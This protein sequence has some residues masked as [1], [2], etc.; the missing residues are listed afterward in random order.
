[1]KAAQYIGLGFSIMH[2]AADE[3]RM[4]TGQSLSELPQLNQ[5]GAG[6]VLKIA[7]SEPA[8]VGKVTI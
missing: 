5:A 3:S 6:V 4:S 1:M 2:S 7:L 8:K